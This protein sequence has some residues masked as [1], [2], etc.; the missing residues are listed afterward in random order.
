MAAMEARLLALPSE[1]LTDSLLLHCDA[2]ALLALMAACR[3]LRD[4]VERP[5]VWQSLLRRR[6]ELIIK[7]LFD[8]KLPQPESTSD[9][10]PTVE[11]DGRAWRRHAFAFEKSWLDIARRQ[12]G[13]LL[14]RMNSNCAALGRPS[15]LGIPSSTTPEISL[16]PMRIRLPLTSVTLPVFGIGWSMPTVSI[17]DVTDFAAQ[18]PGAD[19]LLVEAATEEDST[20]SFDAI[21]H[22]QRARR[23]LMTLT[24]PSLSSMPL[25]DPLLPPPRLRRAASDVA[26]ALLMRLRAAMLAKANELATGLVA[27]RDCARVGVQLVM[28]AAAAPRKRR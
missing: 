27:V 8:G 15:E 1:V 3:E 6:H 7:A 24:V 25:A 10:P 12:T 17:F 9:E 5:C 13:R 2:E 4:V 21:G 23:I 20:L 19:A 18:H 16:I 14:L 26:V 28:E 22:T 11:A